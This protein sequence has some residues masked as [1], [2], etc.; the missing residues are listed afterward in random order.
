M[1][2]SSLATRAREPYASGVPTF[3]STDRGEAQG[4]RCSF[5]AR[6]V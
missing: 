4:L 3:V 5:A 2:L 6:Q 1:I